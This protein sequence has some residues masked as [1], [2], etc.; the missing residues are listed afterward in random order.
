MSMFDKWEGEE[1]C[2]TR[3]PFEVKQ[4]SIST[5]SFL[6]LFNLP[7]IFNLSHIFFHSAM[8]TP[9]YV[10]GAQGFGVA[11]TADNVDHLMKSLTE[12]GINQFDTA[13]L[14]PATN[15][16]ESEELL[17]KKK[18]DNAIIDTKVLFIGDDS[19]SFN[20]MGAS[21]KASLERLQVK[22]VSKRR[23][24]AM[25][26][27]LI[28]AIH[29]STHSTLMPRTARPPSLYKPHTSTITIVKGTLKGWVSPTTV[30]LRSVPGWRSQR[31]KT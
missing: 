28:R 17:G 14:Y 20:N 31:R 15:P 8:D 27:R 12:A 11:W 21:I 10:F 16:G 24:L 5:F 30:H 25:Y 3:L 6:R 9:H 29:R 7:T 23:T 1:V 2:A 19:L 22:K 26:I 18:P 13:A 4:F